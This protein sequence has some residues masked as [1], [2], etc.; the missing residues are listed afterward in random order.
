M[1][2]S[3]EAIR[4]AGSTGTRFS[5]ARMG[6]G[7]QRSQSDID[8]DLGSDCGSLRSVERAVR[9]DRHSQWETYTISIPSMQYA[10]PSP[11]SSQQFPSQTRTSPLPLSPELPASAHSVHARHDSGARLLDSGQQEEEDDDTDSLKGA[12][13]DF[14]NTVE[15][16]LSPRTA[17]ARYFNSAGLPRTSVPYLNYEQVSPFNFDLHASKRRPKRDSKSWRWSLSSQRPSTTN[18]PKIPTEDPQRVLPDGRKR[19]SQV[20][21]DPS[22]SQRPSATPKVS[23]LDMASSPSSSDSNGASSVSQ[24]SEDEQETPRAVEAPSQP[25]VRAPRPLPSISVSVPL[26]MMSSPTSQRD[27]PTRAYPASL[28][29]RT[30][31]SA[32]IESVSTPTPPDYQHRHSLNPIPF[33]TFRPLSAFLPPPLPP[34]LSPPPHAPVSSSYQYQSQYQDAAESPTESFS[35]SI[36][37]IHFRHVDSSAP[38]SRRTS[39]ASQLQSASYPGLY[40]RGDQPLQRRPV[41]PKPLIVQ[42]LLGTQSSIPPPPRDEIQAR[43]T[44]SP[45]RLE[46]LRRVEEPE[47]QPQ[48]PSLSTPFIQRVLRLGGGHERSAS[49]ELSPRSPGPESPG[50]MKNLR[51]F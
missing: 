38:N 33:R 24:R 41:S 5:F 8:I 31:E 4:H 28:S 10:S 7:S 12:E 2:I 51:R 23:F 3:P 6:I 19:L 32:S 29:I 16:N 39:A 26:G 21:F 49:R 42:K 9:K 43:P 17:E 15:I 45:P 40:H 18:V 13:M 11:R 14:H 47:P 35:Y 22:I 1:D 20:H 48:T 30:S 25:P 36:S 50:I 44:F 27:M 34:P 37:D 46:P